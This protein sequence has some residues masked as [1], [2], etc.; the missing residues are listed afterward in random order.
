[1]AEAAAR[2]A[3]AA[4]QAAGLRR[5][6][7]ARR[8]R[9]LPLLGGGPDV[10]AATCAVGLACA[11]A[12][13]GQRTLLIDA[14]APAVAG[15]LGY[16]WRAE[17]SDLLAGRS[18]IGDVLLPMPGDVG[19]VPARK[20]IAEYLEGGAGGDALFGAFAQLSARP[21]LLVFCLD[22]A[23]V[24]LLPQGCELLVVTRPTPD[25]ITATYAKIKQLVSGHGARPLRLLVNCADARE[26]GELHAHMAG[27]ARRFLAA[28]LGYAG[29]V[30]RDPALLEGGA[31][32]APRRLELFRGLAAALGAW[33]LA[34]YG[35]A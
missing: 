19:L 33:R 10:G 15:A 9:L 8:L 25:A 24:R 30:G 31:R 32:S 11:A 13:S 2:T 1:M 14:A 26:A 28:E 17:L 18:Q 5:M 35:S 4:D 3:G 12:E 21:D 23:A 16:T 20:G 34:E 6:L 29:H 22:P 27:V 7:G